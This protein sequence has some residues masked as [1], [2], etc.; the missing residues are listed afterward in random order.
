[1]SD[2]VP[3]G[4]N[5]ALRGA[6]TAGSS[7]K[8]P[9]VSWFVQDDWKVVPRLTVTLGLLYEWSGVPRDEGKQALNA[10][11]NDPG[12]GLI[13][14]KPT[15]DTNNFGPHVGFAWDPTGHGKWSIRGGGQIAYDIIP[16]NFAINSLPPELQTEQN[17]TLT[18]KLSGPPP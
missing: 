7:T 2:C 18:C 8:L 15:S 4:A 6:G 10:I 1:M 13:F 5:G 9:A 16:L 12:V 17:S 14:R 11:A 3:E